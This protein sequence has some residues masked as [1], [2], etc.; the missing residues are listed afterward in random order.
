MFVLGGGGAPLEA[1]E[2]KAGMAKKVF[3]HMY[4]MN[5]DPTKS[6]NPDPEKYEDPVS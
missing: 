2:S 4:N 5:K 1:E 3:S 6:E